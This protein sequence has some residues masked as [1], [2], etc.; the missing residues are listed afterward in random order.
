LQEVQYT[1]Y[2]L[3]QKRSRP[4]EKV[5]GALRS[6]IPGL[7]SSPGRLASF[8]LNGRNGTL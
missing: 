6:N 5:Q 8:T 7:P 1:R 3:L 4:H 2:N